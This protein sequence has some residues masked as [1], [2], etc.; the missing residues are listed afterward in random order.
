MFEKTKKFI[1]EH[2]TEIAFTAGGLVALTTGLIAIH[3]DFK[4]SARKTME[5][6]PMRNI[7][8]TLCDIPNGAQVTSYTDIY[9]EGF[10]P[11]ELGKLGESMI[12]AGA[13]ELEKFTHF[14]AI[15]TVES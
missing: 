3:Y 15:H 14:I 2:K 7:I 9:R 10:T 12:T 11:S 13:D 4:R 6:A 1:K 8:G 5:S